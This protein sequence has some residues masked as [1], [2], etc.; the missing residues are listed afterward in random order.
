MTTTFSNSIIAAVVLA[1]AG[2][3]QAA[4]PCP[5]YSEAQLAIDP[6]AIAALQRMSAYVR[7]QKRFTV[8]TTAHTDYVLDSGQKIRLSSRGDLRVR[9]PDRLRA[10]VVSDRKSRQ[11]FYDGKTFT[12]NGPTTGYYATVAAPPTILELAD[13]LEDRFGIQLPLVDLFR[14]GTDESDISDI[15]SA[16]HIGTTMIDGVVTDQY[17]FR[18][19][20]LD[21]QVW[22]QR[23]DRPL[24][25]K[26]L[27]TTTDDPA[28]PEYSVEMKWE[29]DT[30]YDDKVFTFV[31]TKDNA[32]IRIA[33][34]PPP[35]EYR[36][37]RTRSPSS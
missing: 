27:L 9:R 33:Q 7:E 24:P 35:S 5:P 3:S 15:T 2:S 25:R 31:P 8:H 20:G 22:I 6:Q 37:A 36:T 34:L 10:D 11:F 28:R 17:A 13:L 12:I 14:W 30:K 29:L 1:V 23:G 4:Q 19:A 18:Q 32:R 26:L 21:W 16:I